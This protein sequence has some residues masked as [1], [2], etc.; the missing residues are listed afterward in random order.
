MFARR[1]V[2]PALAAA[3][4]AQA[5]PLRVM[6]FNVRY[7]SPNDG[8]N[9]WE[10]RKDIL[11]DAIRE[12]EP[13]VFGT[14]ELFDLQGR[15]IAEQLPEYEWFGIS[16][17]G[18]HENEHMGVFYRRTT[19][20]VVESGN[21]W[22]SETPSESGS[23]AWDISLPRMVTWA[24][25]RDA[26]GE[27]F[28]FYNTHFPHRRQ[29]AAAR[30]NCAKVIVEDFRRRVPAFAKLIVLGDFNSAADSDVH[31]LFVTELS[32]AWDASQKRSGPQTTSSGWVGRQ[33][34]RRI[35]WILYRGDWKVSE[36]ET[37]DFNV[38][39]Q[40]PSDHYPVFAVFETK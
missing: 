9:V 16:R 8:A 36:V 6:T 3:M 10:N 7:P 29:D 30:L 22:L 11:V 40:Y 17:H 13:D 23:M 2:L 4:L 33:E 26:V 39:G 34:G 28:Y 24:R 20:F 32:D 1:F 15:Y 21:F 12:Y 19:L 14:Q 37:V 5:E 31:R 27:E 25:F 38:G 18:N 35:D